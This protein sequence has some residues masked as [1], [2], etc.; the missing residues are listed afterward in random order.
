MVVLPV[1]GTLLQC[2]LL[3]QMDVVWIVGVY[4][5]CFVLGRVRWITTYQEMRVKISCPV[6]T[7]RTSTGL[8]GFTIGCTTQVPSNFSPCGHLRTLLRSPSLFLVSGN[9]MLFSERLVFRE[10]LIKMRSNCWDHSILSSDH[11]I[12]TSYL[13]PLCTMVFSRISSPAASAVDGGSTC[14]IAPYDLM[15][16]QHFIWLVSTNSYA[17]LALK[18]FETKPEDDAKGQLK[19][20]L[21]GERAAKENHFSSAA[22]YSN[23]RLAW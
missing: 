14:L 6:S 3:R 10:P 4:S 12:P 7:L 9:W 5:L 22:K 15:S 18:Q 19:T 8:S 11:S 23:G 2:R 16:Y 20:Q 13:F 17:I 21:M 1:I